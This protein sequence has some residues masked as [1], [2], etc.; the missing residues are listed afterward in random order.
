MRKILNLES[1]SRVERSQL[2]WFGHVTRM[3]WERLAR[4]VVLATQTGNRPRWSDYISDL[5][6]SRLGMEPAELSE[7]AADFVFNTR[8][9][10]HNPIATP[11]TPTEL[12]SCLLK[13]T[14]S[15]N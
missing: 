14:P 6:S 7:I 12:H 10:Q 5:A 8:R 13:K 9:K 4:K 15:L 1:L 11:T 3:S 2:R